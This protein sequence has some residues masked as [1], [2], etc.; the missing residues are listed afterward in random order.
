[1]L[2]Y[3]IAEFPDD[4]RCHRPERIDPI[5]RDEISKEWLD[6]IIQ[7]IQRRIE[8]LIIH[9]AVISETD[10]TVCYVVEVS[11]SHT[12]HMARKRKARRRCDSLTASARSMLPERFR[13]PRGRRETAL[14]SAVPLSLTRPAPLDAHFGHNT[15]IPGDSSE[16]VMKTCDENAVFDVVCKA[17]S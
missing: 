8:H 16:H 7:T 5:P 3:G 10:N 12:A 2:I 13:R 14:I 1:M 15:P 9:P 4:A 11:Q 6:Q 17:F